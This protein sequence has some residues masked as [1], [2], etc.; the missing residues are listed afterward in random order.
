MTLYNDDLIGVV[1]SEKI[2]WSK[3]KYKTFFI[4]GA[5]GVIGSAIT[6]M[7]LKANNLLDLNLKIVLLVRNV[8]KAKMIFGINEEITFVEGS[9]EC[10]DCQN[11]ID[12]IIHAASPTKS[13]FFIDY[14]IETLDSSVVG[15]KN[16]LE[17]AEKNSIDSMVYLSS[18]ESY[19]TMSDNNV[20]EDKLGYI[21]LFSSRSCYPEGKRVSE[22]YCYLYS[23]QKNVPVKIA[24]LAMTF[25]A[26]LP[27][28]ENRV[29]KQFADAVINKKDIILK[30]AGTTVINYV[31]LS[32]AIE[33]LFI[34]LQ[35][36][37]NGSA[38]NIATD[39]TNMTIKDSA[40]WLIQTYAPGNAVII[41]DSVE[42][43]GLAPNNNMIL[44]NEKIKALGWVPKYN[45]TQGYERL[46][47]YLKY[48]QE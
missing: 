34:I 10:F 38:Y 43:S 15:I 39:P 13:K 4:T 31:Y 14:P 25:G 33:A 20:T 26:G 36:G 35:K 9:N 44:N 23:Y 1:K 2:E 6:K 27:K 48:E 16:I 7:L 28:N 47:E 19:G 21:D 22:M 41:D 18:M 45:L 29:Y 30:S 12:Y 37:E 5:T 24:R 46:I 40:E 3:F 11:H 8:E 32:D 42:K 17:L